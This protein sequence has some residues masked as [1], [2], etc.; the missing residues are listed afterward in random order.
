VDDSTSTADPR[1]TV[2]VDPVF[3]NCSSL[4][5]L[6]NRLKAAADYVCTA[7]S[8]CTHWASSTTSTITYVEGDVAPP[9]GKGIL[10]VTGQVLFNGSETW[11]GPIFVVGTGEF[12]RSGGGSG[13]TWGAIVVANIAGPD[14]VLGTGDDCTGG[15]GGFSPASFFNTNGGG[16]HDTVYCSDL[17]YGSQ[18]A[19]PL[20]VLDFRQR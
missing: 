19:L 1:W 16:N 7:A 4:L 17:I 13:H 11:D 8:P 3:T 5:G 9:S 14:A 12:H 15:T 10:V 6:T 18:S 2:T 20:R